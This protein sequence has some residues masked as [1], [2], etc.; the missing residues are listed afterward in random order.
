M[1]LIIAIINEGDVKGLS[2]GL[3]KNGFSATKF[4]G[5]GLF[6]GKPN[7]VFLIGTEDEKVKNV[8]D[9]IKN[10]CRTKDEHIAPTPQTMEPGELVIP[11][12]EKIK[13]SGAVIF[14]VETE[15]FFKL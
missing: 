5:Q 11:E 15:E 9:I 4:D 1:K 7:T 3:S 12:A 13:T 6:L 10:C 8:V 2:E 14:V